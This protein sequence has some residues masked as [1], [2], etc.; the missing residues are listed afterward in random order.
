MLVDRTGEAH[1]MRM[2]PLLLATV[3]LVAALSCSDDAAGTEFTLR[4]QVVAAQAGMEPSGEFRLDEQDADRG[5]PGEPDGAG[6]LQ[7]RVTGGGEFSETTLEECNLDSNAVR[8]FWTESTDFDPA[9]T[10]ESD[11][12]PANLNGRQVDIDGR[13]FTPSDEDRAA[14]CTLIAEQI[15]VEGAA[16]TAAPAP[17]PGTQE[18]AASPVDSPSPTVT[19][20]FETEDDEIETE[21]P[22][23]TS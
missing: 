12:F 1:V 8:V 4:G 23:E 22:D 15:Q 14:G 6:L 21:E 16:Q 18:P 5:D 19:P 17:A 20:P 9:S 7:V 10:V 11:G 13:V 2:R 3:L